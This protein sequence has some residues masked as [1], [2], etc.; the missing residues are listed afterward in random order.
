MAQV[1]IRNLDEATVAALKAKASAHGRSLEHE[2]RMLLTE[3]AG[4]TR[5]EVRETASRIRALK[6]AAVTIDL[7]QLVREDRER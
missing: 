4:L 5:E 7:D 3:A 6:A 1:L 2:L